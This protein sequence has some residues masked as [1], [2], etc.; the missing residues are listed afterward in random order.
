[1][2]PWIYLLLAWVM[3]IAAAAQN[4]QL[5][6]GVLQFVGMVEGWVYGGAM[7]AVSLSLRSQL[8]SFISR[9]CFVLG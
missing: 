6:L 3:Q 4:I 5:Y 2:R 8:K 7:L 9:K 1:M